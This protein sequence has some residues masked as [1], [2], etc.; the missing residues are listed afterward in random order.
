MGRKDVRGPGW[1]NVITD[2]RT[3]CEIIREVNDLCQSDSEKDREIRERLREIHDM[4]KR[5][6]KKLKDYNKRVFSDWWEKNPEYE[7][8][9]NIRLSKD[10]L[11]DG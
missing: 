8:K 10:Y 1:A 2:K 3:I 6:S 7:K 5:M 9:L 4:A 11:A